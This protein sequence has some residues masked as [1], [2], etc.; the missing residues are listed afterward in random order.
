[1]YYILYVCMYYILYACMY[2]IL[3]VCIYVATS[4]CNSLKFKVGLA[5]GC[6]E[7]SFLTAWQHVL[8]TGLSTLYMKCVHIN[9]YYTLSSTVF[10]DVDIIRMWHPVSQCTVHCL[11]ITIISFVIIQNCTTSIPKY[12]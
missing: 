10:N 2:Y 7:I 12:F 5:D 3:Y 1:M 11:Y 8:V 9:S 6:Y 4:S